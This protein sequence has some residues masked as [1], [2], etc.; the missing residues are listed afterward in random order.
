MAQSMGMVK[1]AETV[2]EK[3]SFRPA[4]IPMGPPK[5]LVCRGATALATDW[6]PLRI[7]PHLQNVFLPLFDIEN[8]TGKGTVQD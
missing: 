6:T 8:G 5:D 3:S 1:K 7:E 4:I 2:E